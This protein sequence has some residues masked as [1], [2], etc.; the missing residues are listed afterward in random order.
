MLVD[1]FK[2]LTVTLKADDLPLRPGWGTTGTAIKLRSNYFAVKLPK[3]P[4]Y[5]YDVKITPAAAA[6]RMN[7]RIFALLEQTPGFAPYRGAVAHD[8]SAK[9]IAAKKLPQPLALTVPYFDEDESGPQPGGKTYTVEITFIQDLD[10]TALSR[11]VHF[12]YHCIV[13]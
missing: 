3:G 10:V 11:S 12:F 4:L 8:S 1:S 6:R 2:S 7:R 9:L 5:E 13:S